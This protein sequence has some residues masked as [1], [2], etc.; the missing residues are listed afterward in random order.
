MQHSSDASR[1]ATLWN[2]AWNDSR[3]T[4]VVYR[5]SAGMQLTIE[6][7]DAVVIMEQFELQPRAVA[8]AHA[9]R[10]ALKRRGWK[11]AVVS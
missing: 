6:S 3:L 2:M 7:P 8:R 10:E 11:D 5:T 9:L 4:C 1:L